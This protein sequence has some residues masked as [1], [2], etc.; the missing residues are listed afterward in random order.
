MTHWTAT[1]ARS[2]RWCSAQGSSRASA[3]TGSGTSGG[4]SYR[5]QWKSKH[6]ETV[7]RLSASDVDL[8]SGQVEDVRS[9]LQ[10][11][12]SVAPV[13]SFPPYYRGGYEKPHEPLEAHFTWD[14]PECEPLSDA[15]VVDVLD[16]VT[17]RPYWLTASNHN[18]PELHR[19]RRGVIKAT[20]RA[21]PLLRLRNRGTHAHCLASPSSRSRRPAGHDSGAGLARWPSL[22]WSLNG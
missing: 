14:A 13:C 4:R 18:V 2:P 21:A 20:P 16:A 6:A 10:T 7:E 12:S 19:Y 5:D 11:V 22:G 3:A 9:W 1:L 8:A 15:D 17:D